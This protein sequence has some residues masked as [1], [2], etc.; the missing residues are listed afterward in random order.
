M[1]SV[2]NTPFTAGQQPTTS[3][4]NNLWS[5]DVG[6]GNGTMITNLEFGSQTAV[7]LDY[8]FRVYLTATQTVTSNTPT[9]V[10]FDTVDYDTGSNFDHTTNFRFIP[11]VSGFYFFTSTIEQDAGSGAR[12]LVSLY[13]TGVEKSRGVNAVAQSA[14]GSASVTDV[15]QL[16]TSDYVEAWFNTSGTTV[17]GTTLDGAY[18]TY[19][20]GF[21]LSAT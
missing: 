19:M 18:A 8:K 5:N 3:Y 12:N 11:P 20:T 6:L 9:K 13:K 1:G 7:K 16:T 21:L 17:A 15:L 10:H 4:W 2:T 14:L